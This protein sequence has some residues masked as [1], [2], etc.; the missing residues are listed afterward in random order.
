MGKTAAQEEM[1]RWPDYY[2]TGKR[3]TGKITL[4]EAIRIRQQELKLGMADSDLSDSAKAQADEAIAKGEAANRTER[5]AREKAA[6]ERREQPR[7]NTR[8]AE[9][10]NY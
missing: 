5:E 1:D 3:E 8:D 6:T 10:W 4:A 9:N 7:Y 2:E